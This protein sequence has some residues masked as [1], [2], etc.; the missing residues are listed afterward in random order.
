MESLSSIK[1]GV[2]TRNCR[3]LTH[4]KEND[5]IEYILLLFQFNIVAQR[6][7]SQK[8]GFIAVDDLNFIG[9]ESDCEF[10]PAEAEPG[11]QPSTTSSTPVPTEGPDCNVFLSNNRSIN[12]LYIHYSYDTMHL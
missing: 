2:R 7:H 11:Y 8:D 10:R 9:T 4:S 5:W 6:G 1:G 12:C 3:K